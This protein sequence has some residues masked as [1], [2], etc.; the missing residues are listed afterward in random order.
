MSFVVYNECQHVL[1][2]LRY[3]VVINSG[4]CRPG[5]Y[6]DHRFWNPLNSCDIAGNLKV[7]GMD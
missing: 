7:K 1:V 3:F 4:I 5:L 6:V 2:D